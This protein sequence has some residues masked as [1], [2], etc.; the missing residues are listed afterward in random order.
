[1]GCGPRE[2][3]F[4]DGVQKYDAVDRRQRGAREISAEFEQILDVGDF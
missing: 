4:F 1:M 2:F 3:C